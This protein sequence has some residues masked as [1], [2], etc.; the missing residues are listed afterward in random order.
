MTALNKI[1]RHAFHTYPLLQKAKRL[2]VLLALTAY[3]PAYAAEEWLTIPTSSDNITFSIDKVNLERSGKV[4]KF[5]EKIVY[6]QP[7]VKDETSGRMIKEK[8]MRRIM[9]CA[10][11]TQGLLHGVTY[12]DQGKFITSLSL[13]E[14]KTS[15][16][17]IPHNTVAETEFE[18]VC[19]NI[20]R[21]AGL[22]AYP[23]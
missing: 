17:A 5:W 1:E 11:R 12:S 4:V 3:I 7:T 23:K 22:V 21:Q 18:I 6:L 2:A 10:E 9:N 14:D 16:T 20:P 19:A 15:M 8:K 13:D